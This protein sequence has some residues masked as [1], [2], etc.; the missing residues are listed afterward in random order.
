MRL[1]GFGA[2]TASDIGSG[3]NLGSVSDIFD[4]TGRSHGLKSN[5]LQVNNSIDTTPHDQSDA[6]STL[7]GLVWLFPSVSVTAVTCLYID[8]MDFS[9]ISQTAASHLRAS[10][11]V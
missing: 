8:I 1:D 7:L 6:C 9:S 4:G 10:Q 3:L 11:Q 5:F 2:V